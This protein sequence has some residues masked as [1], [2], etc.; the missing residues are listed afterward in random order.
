VSMVS[1]VMAASSLGDLLSDF[2]KSSRS[3]APGI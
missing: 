1:M 3:S 2:L